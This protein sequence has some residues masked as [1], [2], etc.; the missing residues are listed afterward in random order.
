MTVAIVVALSAALAGLTPAFTT[1]EWWF[2]SVGIVLVVAFAIAAVRASTRFLFLPQTAGVL[3]LIFGLTLAFAP[4]A[5]IIGFIPTF[6]VFGAFSMLVLEAIQSIQNQPIPADTVPGIVFLLAAGAGLMTILIDLLAVGM[7]RPALTGIP[8]LLLVALP[9]ILDPGLTDPF[10][11]AIAAVGYL[12]VLYVGVGE[13]RAGGAVAVGAVAVV[14]A[15]LAPLVLPPTADV[16]NESEAGG[17]TIGVNTFISL[18]ENLRQ[19]NPSRVLTYTTDTGGGQYLALSVIS[20]FEGDQ[21]RPR[22][23]EDPEGDLSEIDP[24]PGLG[25]AVTTT[26]TRTE[27]RIVNMG[28]RWLPAP[29][30]PTSVTGLEGDWGWDERDRTITTDTSTVRG[31]EYAVTNTLATP[32]IEVLRAAVLGDT[33]GLE[34]FLEIPEELP[35]SVA[36][37]ALEVT[38]GAT[39]DFDRAVALQEYFTDGEF[40]Y[41]EE[42]PVEEDYDGS[43]AEIVGR[44]LEAKAGYCVHFSSAMAVMARTLDIP[45]R[46]VVGFTPGTVVEETEEKPAFW[47]VST[48]NLHAW[49]ELWFEGVGWVRFEPTVGRGSSPDFINPAPTDTPIATLTPGEVPT[50][51]PTATAAPTA[52]PTPTA[53][54]ITAPDDGGSVIPLVAVSAVALAALIVLLMPLLPLLVRTGRRLVR[55]DRVLRRGSPIAAW[56]ELNDT[57]IDLGWQAETMTPREF[58]LLVRTGMP[59]ETIEALGRLLLATEATAYSR[60]PGTVRLRDLREVRRGMAKASTRHERLQ[61][62]FSPRSAQWRR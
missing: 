12:A 40:T 47:S 46:I 50:L 4:G 31:Q 14:G 51:S 2:F 26:G 49:P 58:A 45:S 38:A 21:W 60:E 39:T 48:A 62:V 1:P 33:S 27:V 55:Y 42:T 6:E 59:Q 23:P 34:D 41:S 43:S 52:T 13:R 10:W 24:A 37:T 25:P 32:E 28:G 18:G 30:S 9:T 54:P 19:P 29:Y 7:R 20:D 61:A 56:H 22:Q 36:E 35:E 53:G 57:G 3:V 11:F 5:A 44:F 8:L 15:L 17:F 16:Q